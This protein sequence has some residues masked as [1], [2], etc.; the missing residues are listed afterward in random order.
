M[1]ANGDIGP[2]LLVFLKIEG[3]EGFLFFARCPFRW[4][5]A[6]LI[7]PGF[8]RSSR[9]F[10]Y[11]SLVCVATDSFLFVRSGDMRV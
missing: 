5:L 1:V 7:V 10:E 9:G 8:P 4:L 2:F 6:A 11:G 3:K